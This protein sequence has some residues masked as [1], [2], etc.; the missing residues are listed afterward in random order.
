MKAETDKF[1]QFCKPFA[2]LSDESQDK[3]V[4]IA[5]SLL[6]TQ[7]FAKHEAAAKKPNKII[8]TELV[9]KLG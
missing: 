6:K 1:A 4:R 2:E 9:P 7:Q 3:L 8:K 5:Q